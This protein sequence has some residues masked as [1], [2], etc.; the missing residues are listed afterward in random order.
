MWFVPMLANCYDR[1]RVQ[2]DPVRHTLKRVVSRTYAVSYWESNRRCGLRRLE[3]PSASRL[4][5][6]LAVSQGTRHARGV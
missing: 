3:N 2:N 4:E 1:K 6:V 5:Y